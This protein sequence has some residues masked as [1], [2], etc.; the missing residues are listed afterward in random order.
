MAKLHF[1]AVLSGPAHVGINR[2]NRNFLQKRALIEP[3]GALP[4]DL[5]I[6][7]PLNVQTVIW[8]GKVLEK[9]INKFRKAYAMATLP[10]LIALKEGDL[11]KII[12][13]TFKANP[14]KLMTT[15]QLSRKSG[16]PLT[17]VEGEIQKS[18]KSGKLITFNKQGFYRKEIYLE[19]KKKLME[20]IKKIFI[21]D[22]L[23]NT[24][25]IKEI[26]DRFAPFMDE[27]LFRKMLSGLCHKK[28][29]RKNGGGY[30]V[31]NLS[32]R[33][34]TQ[35]ENLAEV[36][37]D[38]ADK[39]GYRTFSVGGFCILNRE[40]YQKNRVI[41][42]LH[43]LCEQ[44]K[45]TQLNDGHYISHQAME[46]IKKDVEK[47]IVQKGSFNLN[48]SKEML[49]YGRKRGIPVLEYLD[50]IGFTRREGDGRVLMTD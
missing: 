12:E 34:T 3:I 11:K 42:I 7:C 8:G 13:Y 9:T 31:P 39:I 33:I 14:D 23:K 28:Q 48:D 15:E 19:Q 41:K 35:Q 10:L 30:Q 38:H 49:G 40:K 24:A 45:I 18:I 4:Q 36:L 26:K 47:T 37:L 2:K 21:K 22:S 20:T 6:V 27:V 25:N 17:K 32:T 44:E 5:F 1:F 29:L 16:F 50:E 46:Q 43:H